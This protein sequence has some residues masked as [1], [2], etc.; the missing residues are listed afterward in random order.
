MRVDWEKV[1]A[2]MI[3]L[4]YNLSKFASRSEG[5]FSVIWDKPWDGAT[6]GSF[7]SPPKIKPRD[8]EDEWETEESDEEPELNR[9]RELALGL[10]AQDPYG[11][12][13]SWM[14]VVCFLDYNDLYAFNFSERIPEGQLREGIDTEE[15]TIIL[16]EC[17]SQPQN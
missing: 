9:V 14:R 6:A 4:G 15:G 11:V 10:D 5:R 16:C 17:V 8:D 1:E 7:R 2:V 13:G 3:V 12:S